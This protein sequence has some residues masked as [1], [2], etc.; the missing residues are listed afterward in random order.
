MVRSEI[1]SVKIDSVEIRQIGETTCSQL[2]NET[3][4]EISNK[5]TSGIENEVEENT[6]VSEEEE[7]GK[8]LHAWNSACLSYFNKGAN[9]NLTIV[10][11]KVTIL[12]L[13]NGWLRNNS[14]YS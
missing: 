8:I 2:N 10:K 14:L 3:P 7:N 12:S 4:T 6:D 5:T 1:Q 9:S 13:C 11:M